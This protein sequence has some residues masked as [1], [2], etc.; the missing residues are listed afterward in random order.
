M[1][2]RTKV[3]SIRRSLHLSGVWIHIFG[4][5]PGLRMH[6]GAWRSSVPT[7]PAGGQ[8]ILTVLA[9]FGG[10]LR[11]LEFTMRFAICSGSLKLE[12]SIDRRLSGAD[13][14]DAYEGVVKQSYPGVMKLGDCTPVTLAHARG[15]TGCDA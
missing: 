15:R 4:I 9:V 7:A 1:F 12:R 11:R 3:L 8:K 6:F 13:A 10:L 5:I 2:E 14:D